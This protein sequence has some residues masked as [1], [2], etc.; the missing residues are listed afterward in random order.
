VNSSNNSTGDN[1]PEEASSHIPFLPRI[2][3]TGLFSGYIPWSSGTFGTLVGILFYLIPGAESSPV[4]AAM[5][6][7]GFFV[8]VWASARVAEVVGHQLTRTAELTKQMFQQGSHA[9]ADPSI[10][11]IDEIVG[12]WI[13]LLFL[14]KTVPV[15]I[16]GFLAFRAFDILK[17]Q[18]ARMLERIPHGWGIMLDDVA[19]AI[20]ANIATRVA[21]YLWTLV[22]H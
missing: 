14:P 11:V 22:I 4:L 2:I 9:T 16:I 17:P 12:I 13:T 1:R 3:A 15:I 5:S 8:G 18:P 10:V 7:I 21:W 20:Y 6:T 19:A